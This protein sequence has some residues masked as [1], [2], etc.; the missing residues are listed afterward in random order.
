MFARNQRDG[1]VGTMA[2]TAL[3]YLDI[4]IVTRS[5]DMALALAYDKVLTLQV[6]QQFLVVK[7]AVPSVHLGYL[8]LQVGQITL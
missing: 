5:G 2:I 3:A 6:L 7:L 4:C 1:A 8:A